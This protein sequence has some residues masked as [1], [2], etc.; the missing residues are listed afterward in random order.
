MYVQKNPEIYLFRHP[1]GCSGQV[2]ASGPETPGSTP[3]STEGSPCM[4][5]C[6]S[7]NHMLEAKRLWCG[8]LERG[9]QFRCRPVTA[10]QIYKVHPKIILVF[11]Q[12]GPLT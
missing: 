12:S 2:S 10:I 1:Q 3:D 11:L 8:S 6:C 7:L 9:C 4:W 5:A